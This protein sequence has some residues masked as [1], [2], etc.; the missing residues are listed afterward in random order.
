MRSLLSLLSICLVATCVLTSFSPTSISAQSV[1]GSNQRVAPETAGQRE[2]PDT[3]VVCPARFQESLEPWIAYRQQQGH[4]LAVI[5]P[6]ASAQ[7]LKKTIRER[8]KQ[9]SSLQNIVLIGDSQGSSD[10]VPTN[11]IDANVNVLFGAQPNIAT[12]N[13]FADLDDDGSPDLVIGRI[14]VDSPSEL[15]TAIH[16]VIEYEQNNSGPWLQRINFIAGVGGFGALVDKMIE[17]AAKQMIT[18][19]IPA[20]YTTSMTYGSWNSPYCPDPRKFADTSIERFNEGC[21][22]WVYI[23]HGATHQ[24]DR[25]R[26]PDRTYNILD[27]SNVDKLQSKHG[28]PIAIF[29][30]CSTGG[31]DHRRDCLAERMLKQESGPIAVLASTRVAMPY[32]LSTFTLEMTREHFE[33]ESKTLGEI[34]RVAKQRL[35]TAK[36][37]SDLRKMIEAM[38]K[39][40]SP[41]PELLE[42]ERKEHADLIHLL[43]DP[44]LRVKRGERLDLHADVDPVKNQIHLNGTMPFDGKLHVTVC[45]KRDRFRFRPPRRPSYDPEQFDDYQESYD[46]AQQLTCFAVEKQVTQGDMEMTIEIPEGASGE[47]FVQGLLLTKDNFALDAAPIRLSR[48]K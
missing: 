31:F 11:Y 22:F 21:L 20:G 7:Q 27:E 8:C 6:P 12:D 5:E 36:D 4:V 34:V 43:G 40:F 23:G 35:I 15:Q 38:G 44:L 30:A 24:L 28:S 19:L 17:Q 39:G 46:Q 33:G 14:P 25:I 26:L 45:Y 9:N 16:R 13:R 29:L 1:Q 47:C 32:G 42:A 3:L 41:K 48:R 10:T 2:N 37:P 18:D